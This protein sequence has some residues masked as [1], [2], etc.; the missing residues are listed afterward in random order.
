MRV[1]TPR[2]IL[3]GVLPAALAVLAFGAC[4]TA[5]AAPVTYTAVLDGPSEFPANASPGTGSAI[6]DIDAVAHTMRVQVAFSGLIGLTT[7]S[8]IHAPT[9]V[10]LTGTA[11]VATITPTFTGF[12]LGVTAGTYDNTY[13]TSLPTAWNPTYVTNNGGTPLSAETALF[14]AIAAG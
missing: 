2:F 10:A 1:T 5:G 4:T 3:L 13:D 14:T 8:H 12:P 6:V 11:G 7:A 9:A